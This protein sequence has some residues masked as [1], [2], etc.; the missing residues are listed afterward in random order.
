MKKKIMVGLLIVVI[1][2]N[3]NVYGASE[4]TTDKSEINT[5]SQQ[6][7][8]LTIDEAVEKGLKNSILMNKIKNQA[9]IAVL[10][11]D[12]A[13]KNKN[14]IYNAQNELSNAESD[15]N[16]GRS[17]I[18]SSQRQLESAQVA[19]DNGIA[20]QDIPI[21]NPATGEIIATIHQGENIDQALAAYGLSAYSNAVKA[22]I[23]SGIDAN[24]GKI[25]G[26]LED[27]DE[28][29]QKYV[30]GK[31]KY[32]L[33]LQFA[34]TRVASKLSTS[35]IS[36]LE[37]T[38]LADLIVEMSD[39]QDRITSY[40]V[41]I[42]KNKMA[43]L[44]QNSYYEALKQEKLLEMKEKAMQRGQLQYDYA[45]YAYEV[46]AKSK[47]DMNIAKLYYDGTTMAYELQKKDYNNAMIELNKNINIPLDTKLNLVE[48]TPS[49]KM[50]FNLTQGI[51]SGLRTRLEMKMAEAQVELYKDLMAAVNG[52][53]YDEDDNQYKEVD[54]LLKKAEIE[55]ADAKLQTESSIRMSYETIS[56]MEKV[57][58]IA[59]Q[60]KEKADEGV[61]IAKLKYEVGF[62]A[63]NNLMK[64][65]NLQELSGTMVEVIA[66]EE[67]LAAIEEKIVEVTN[68]YNLAKAKYLNDIGILPYK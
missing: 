39:I 35:T 34:M 13:E 53:S 31:S 52:S 16:S 22:Q 64:S 19:L 44:I 10:V 21:P 56:S 3:L 65:L 6:G 4:E 5:I 25:S 27:L 20:P 28:G 47:D 29:T 30:S 26:A 54:F 46:G 40:S 23:Q 24:K 58:E 61:E 8:T 11:S 55:R 18:Y 37:A 68:G 51:N 67:N 49:T 60:L 2:F 48:V 42:Y 14:D 45:N 12:N 57:A 62:G 63:D 50:S 36:S 32:D 15:L 66:A 9:E 43:L 17:T 59:S 41:N 33:S 38:H 7:L 1:T